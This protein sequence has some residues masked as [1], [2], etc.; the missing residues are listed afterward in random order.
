[1]RILLATSNPHKRDEICAI[2]AACGAAGRV[3]LV[4][5][6]ELAPGD[7]IAEPVENGETFEANAI[8]KAC[9]YAEAAGMLCLADD[10]GLEVDAL[11][12]EPGV[13]SAR[14][15]GVT[16]DRATIDLANN[17]LLL[18]KLGDTPADR[19]AA[20]FVCAMAL[21]APGDD[22][23]PDALAAWVVKQHIVA[24][25]QTGR[26]LACVRGTVEGRILTPDEAADPQ[27]PE[28]GRGVNGFG[29]DPLFMLPDRGCTSAEL[30]PERKNAISHRGDAAR[31][32]WA[33]LETML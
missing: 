26:L 15:S 23:L 20:R 31:K 2:F 6:D 5:L 33:K 29:Y 28:R 4:T 12:G 3:E 13:Y 19:R 10:S 22:R 27:Q 7:P 32:M 14:Y 17:R 1:M 18:E 25:T 9:H 8:L 30:T 21:C 11:S 24:P 16:G